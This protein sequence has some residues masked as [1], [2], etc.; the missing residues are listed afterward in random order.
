M[1]SCDSA[2]FGVWPTSRS[3]ERPFSQDTAIISHICVI[4]HSESF[5]SNKYAFCMSLGEQ[6]LQISAQSSQRRQTQDF[7]YFCLLNMQGGFRKHCDYFY[8]ITLDLCLSVSK[9]N[10][11][12]PVWSPLGA[13]SIHGMYWNV[14]FFNISSPALVNISW[15]TLQMY[16]SKRRR[17]GQ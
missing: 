11:Q 15:R 7:Y 6:T 13:S 8:V 5:H 12:E 17:N 16:F 14:F 10:N 2:E 9:D 4:S 1:P 3:E